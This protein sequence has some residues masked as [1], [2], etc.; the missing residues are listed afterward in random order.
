MGPGGVFWVEVLDWDSG[1]GYR[2]AGSSC[3]S[4]ML[5]W[6]G[7]LSHAGLQL[8]LIWPPEDSSLLTGVGSVLSPPLQAITA[9]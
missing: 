4:G 2:V 3:I 1:L 8:G 9:R 6:V 7:V 5:F